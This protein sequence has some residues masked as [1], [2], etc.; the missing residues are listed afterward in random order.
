MRWPYWNHQSGA[1]DTVGFCDW[2]C[3]KNRPN[4]DSTVERTR[5]LIEESEATRAKLVEC[6]DELGEHVSDLRAQI[7]AEL[8]RSSE[9]QAP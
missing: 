5:Q 3:P 2:L 1:D 7:R 8:R 6:V 4:R 9:G